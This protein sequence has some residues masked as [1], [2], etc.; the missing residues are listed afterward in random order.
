MLST[1][2]LKKNRL[3]CSS[4][5][6]RRVWPGRD[7]SSVVMSNDRLF[8]PIWVSGSPM[9]VEHTVCSTLPTASV[10]RTWN[11]WFGSLNWL[12]KFW[13]RSDQLSVACVTTEGTTKDCATLRVPGP[14]E[15]VNASKDPEI[16]GCG[17]AGLAG[18]W[19]PLLICQPLTP[20]TGVTVQPLKLPASKLPLVMRLTPL[21]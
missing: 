5:T 6:S 1:V 19:I 2:T 21:G 17:V 12:A 7:W 13:I 10:I 15:S 11:C 16:G 8:G 18:S 14:V 4:N 9:F 3:S 20:T